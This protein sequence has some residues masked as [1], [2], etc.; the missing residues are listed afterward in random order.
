MTQLATDPL[1]LVHLAISLAAIATGLPV[2]GEH[3]DAVLREELALTPDE[4]ARLRAA[5]VIA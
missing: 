1:T 4:L 2:L 3:T 5:T